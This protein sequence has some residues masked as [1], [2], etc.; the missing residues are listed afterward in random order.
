MRLY[1][2]KEKLRIQGSHTS[3]FFSLKLSVFSVSLQLAS[4]APETSSCNISPNPLTKT[5]LSAVTLSQN[6]PPKTKKNS[7][8]PF[9]TC[10]QAQR[11][12]PELS[13]TPHNNDLP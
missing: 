8:A 5:P 9:Q 11:N 13:A 3:L 6:L 12:P 2:D 7:P 1:C 4:Q 10:P